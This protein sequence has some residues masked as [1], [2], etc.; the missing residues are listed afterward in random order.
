M[1]PV[2]RGHDHHPGL[3]SFNHAYLPLCSSY[4]GFF[5]LFEKTEL[6]PGPEP[7]QILFPLP[8]MPFFQTFAAFNPSTIC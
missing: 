5:L 2:A 4:V 7:L 6:T 8:G 1:F 3:L